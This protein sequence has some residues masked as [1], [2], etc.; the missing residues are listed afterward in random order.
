MRRSK[1]TR[2]G[3]WSTGSSTDSYSAVGMFVREAASCLRVVTRRGIVVRVRFLA[4]RFPGHAESVDRT[5][6]SKRAA[7]ASPKSV[8]IS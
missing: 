4:M 3:S 5:A 6:S 8:S 7:T 1:A 2:T